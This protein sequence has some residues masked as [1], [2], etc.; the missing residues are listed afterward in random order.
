MLQRPSAK[1][2]S[3]IKE[4]QKGIQILE[5]NK[6][7]ST[8][9][10]QAE[11]RKQRV[12]IEKLRV[13]QRALKRC[14]DDAKLINTAASSKKADPEALETNQQRFKAI[15]VKL[16]RENLKGTQL[17][18]SLD[19][20]VGNLEDTRADV[21]RKGGVEVASAI[22]SVARKHILIMESRLENALQ[23][24]NSTLV[25]NKDYKQQIE[26]ERYERAIYEGILKK[27]E[28]DI[29]AKKKA[30]ATEIELCNAH[31][32]NREATIAQMARLKQ[33][34][35]Q[36]FSDFSK[37]WT[38]LQ[39]MIETDERLVEFMEKKERRTFD[40]KLS[41]MSS[42]A[43]PHK[44]L[45]VDSLVKVR[46]HLK[47][48]HVACTK[49]Q[50]ATGYVNMDELIQRFLDA[51]RLFFSMYTGSKAK[52]D[53]ADKIKAQGDA[54]EA[55]VYNLRGS[56]LTPRET[57]KRHSLHDL[58]LKAGES[59]SKLEKSEERLADAMS[60]FSSLALA[61]HNIAKS[62][63]CDRWLFDEIE[64]MSILA[65]VES[66]VQEMLVTYA[67]QVGNISQPLQSNDDA[68]RDKAIPTLPSSVDD[69]SDLEENRFLT[70][71]EL[72]TKIAESA[73]RPKKSVRRQQIAKIR[74]NIS[75]R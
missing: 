22:Q 40:L 59:V 57:L 60:K 41:S 1:I 68:F 37:E 44:G 48:L 55:Q 43:T 9:S 2:L 67:V 70:R 38:E 26:V 14:V 46:T 53:E 8:D 34:A 42:N 18:R 66:K 58:G 35:D 15:E 54:L 33:K 31:Y 36:E 71:D 3:D 72:Q 11:V 7:S 4:L 28:E 49:L 13:E 30:V 27:T 10:S 32:A 24:Y 25:V 45:D 5:S 61:I 64:I 17:Q 39:K 52:S 63:D 65:S 73:N 50:E 6:R 16:E 23:R 12:E 20:L 47:E 51:D 29:N 56:M 74:K 62:I 75:H 69:E 19:E 21:A